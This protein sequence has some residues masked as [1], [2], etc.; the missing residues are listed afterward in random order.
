[1]VIQKEFDLTVGL[2]ED[3][4][5]V[6]SYS[7]LTPEYSTI[8]LNL[9]I[10]R[11]R[12]LQALLNKKL[13]WS[14]PCWVGVLSIS[15]GYG[16]FKLAD[17]F[18]YI[19]LQELILN[20]NFRYELISTLILAGMVFSIFFALFALKTEFLRADADKLVEESEK[21][22]GFDL[23][24]YSNLP[25]NTV[26]EYKSLRK[27]DDKELELLE[28]GKNSQIV[29]YRETPIAVI[30]LVVDKD[31]NQTNNS[32]YVVRIQSFGIRRVY[33][34]SGIM[35]ELLIWAL[36][37]TRTIVE[38]LNAS[39]VLVLCELYS[40]EKD[41]IPTFQELTFKKIS[42]RP[43]KDW[44]LGGIY[45]VTQDTWA[46]GLLADGQDGSSKEAVSSDSKSTDPSG[47]RKRN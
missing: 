14:A 19:P 21:A 24:A 43:L 38:A 22:F 18:K 4:E 16:Y 32:S 12:N 3:K 44:L 2:S 6:V 7:D 10:D 34:K 8:S 25:V 13:L 33:V 45:G 23:K 30:S 42:S 11:R 20:N 36:Y 39:E 37:R 46:I 9:V 1:M 41:V 35:K 31:P 15:L 40:F 5:A 26:D 47:L 29:I 27:T 17:Y 28:N